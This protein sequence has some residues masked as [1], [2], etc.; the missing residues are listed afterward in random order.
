MNRIYD[1]FGCI[2][3]NH[4]I[5]FVVILVTLS[6]VDK[7]SFIKSTLSYLVLVVILCYLVLVVNFILP[8]SCG[9]FY[10]TLYLWSTLSYLV[11]VVNFIL[12]LVLVVNFI[13]YLVL[14]V[15]VI[16]P[17]TV[18]VVNFILPCTS[19]QLYPT[20]YLWST[21][22]KPTVGAMLSRLCPTMDL[23]TTFQTKW[24]PLTSLCA[25]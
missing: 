11:L 14:V 4:I 6:K 19:G 3:A 9:Q 24:P 22:E 21:L 5:C 16:L 10:P 12:Y 17:C 2:P 18:R 20:L 15:N 7:V 23:V 1:N 8:C 13:L 25:T